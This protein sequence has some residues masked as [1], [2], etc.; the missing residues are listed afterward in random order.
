MTR[1]QTDRTDVV[2]VGGG[3]AGITAALELL[4]LG[5]RVTLLDGRDE[6]HFGGQARHAFGG[7][8]LVGTPEQKHRRIPDSPELALA[9]WQRA[10]AFDHDER[11]APR[12]A[13]AYVNRCRTEVYDW[14]HGFGLRFFPMVHW[15]ERGN[16]GDGNSVPRY[17][18]VWGCGRGLTDTLK[19]R[20]LQHPRR[21]QLTLR[22]GHRVEDL[23][24]DK[25]AV[26][27]VT[28]ANA[29]G[30]FILEADHIVIA[31][32]GINGNP[33]K[34]RANWDPDYGPAPG[35]LLFG[36]SPHADGHLHDRVA[37]VGGQVVK[38]NQMWNYAAGI[39][40]PQ[41]RFPNHGLSLIP[42][43]S[44]LWLDAEG[45]RIGPRPLVTGFDTHD[46]CR[47]LGHL[48]GQ[49]GWLL[50]NRRIALRELGVAGS[51]EN[52]H[53]RDHQLLPLMWEAL[54]G[55]RRLYKMLLANPDVAT[56]T[57]FSELAQNMNALTGED[58]VNSWVMEED[59]RA[60]DESIRRGGRFLNDEQVQRIR[61]LRLWPGERIRTCNLQPINDSWAGPLLAIR[62]RL[63]SRKSMGGM[64][65]DLHSRVLDAHGMPIPGLYAAGEAAGFGGG[66]I[67]GKRSLEGTFLSCAMF[68]ARLAARAIAGQPNP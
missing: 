19:A 36:A 23:V 5:L 6:D 7:M 68:N 65:T 64:L 63:I 54:A 41:P 2:V 40:H 49:Y 1:I 55:N 15:V 45:K 25:G 50:M 27:A 38:L 47:R 20:L 39:P 34:V 9:D 28:G 13:E 43:R 62:T 61:Q 11:W 24:M 32:G 17:H 44:A 8:L 59:V 3:I 46:L 51:D 26:T 33:D 12:W 21:D 18:I 42:A 37:A 16:D 30:P 58:R 56:G 29:G 4:D 67:A 60:Y 66:G 22:F 57:S 31:G 35:N 52:P 14:L 10:A 53:Y 48:P